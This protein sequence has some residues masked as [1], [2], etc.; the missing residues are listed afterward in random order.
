MPKCRD[1]V[2]PSEQPGSC[3]SLNV[4]GAHVTAGCLR[5]TPKAVASDRW[6]EK[7]SRRYMWVEPNKAATLVRERQL[8]DALRE[9]DRSTQGTA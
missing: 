7:E 4:I 8:A 1:G 6:I 2:L 3:V 5:S 9:F